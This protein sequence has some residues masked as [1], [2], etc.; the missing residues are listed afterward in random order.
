[1]WEYHSEWTSQFFAELDRR[2]DPG[3]FDRG[4]APIIMDLLKR[5]LL[6]PRYLQHS[7]RVLFVVGQVNSRER[8][9]ILEAIFDLSPG[10]IAK[11]VH[12]GALDKI[13]LSAYDYVYDIFPDIEAAHHPAA[14]SH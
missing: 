12:G 7:A 9:Q 1:M 4:K 3:R 2:G 8:A 10:E 6:S 13:A 14:G 11:R 5:Q